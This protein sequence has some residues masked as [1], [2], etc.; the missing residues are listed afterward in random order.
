MKTIHLIRHAKSSWDN[1]GLSD[2]NR[3]LA[4]RGINDC[5]IMGKH[6]I[7]AG[8]NHRQ[9]Y[10]SQARRAQQTISGIADSMPQMRIEWQIDPQLYTFSS[11]VLVDWLSQCEDEFNALTLVGHNPAFTDLIN[12]LSGAHLPNLPTCSYAQLNSNCAVWA[13]IENSACKMTQFLR[14]KMFK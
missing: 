12:C 14:P 11:G 4:D 7:A 9:I 6:L 13:E 3:P 8:W 5:E 10:C 1:P 2:I